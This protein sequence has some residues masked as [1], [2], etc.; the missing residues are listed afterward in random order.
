MRACLAEEFSAVHVLNLRGNQRTQ[1]ERSRQEGGKIFGQGSREPVAISVLVRNPD[2][3]H[4]GCRILYHDIGDYLTRERKLEMLREWGSIEGIDNWLQIEPNRHHDW[5][6]QRDEAYERLYPVGTKEA[7]SGQTDN[8]VFRLFSNGYK[9]GRDAYV[10]SFSRDACASHAQKM[11]ED[12][13]GALRDWSKC[14]NGSGNLDT[15]VERYCTHIRWDRE[16]KRRL[17]QGVSTAFSDQNIRQVIYRPFVKQNLYADYTFSQAPGHTQDI[18]PAD[19]SENRAICLPG[20]GSIKPFSALM[21]D[22]MPDLHFAAFGQ[23]FPALPLCA[24]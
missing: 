14:R 8:A 7:K 13:G 24:A 21:V 20:V 9:T 22:C 17:R 2:A 12:Y 15:I 23:C 6:S 10:Y 4:E 19:A 1:G 5:I 18:F 16:L 3:K 11:V